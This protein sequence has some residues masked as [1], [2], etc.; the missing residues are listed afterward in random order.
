MNDITKILKT[1]IIDENTPI[2]L[3]SDPLIKTANV[4][5][6]VK[7]ED[8]NNK[9]FSGNKWHKLKYN[10][11]K[12]KE[13]GY[14]KL[15]TFGGAF[16]NHIYAVAAAGRIFG[17]ETIGIIRGEEYKQ[18]NPTLSFAR[19]QGMKFHYI[20][21]KTYRD[22]YNKDLLN[23]FRQKFGNFYLIPE[24]GTNELAVNGVSEFVSKINVDYDYICCSCG[25]GGTLA[26]IIEGVD[27]K[28]QILG[29][30]VL[31]GGEFLIKNVESL[32]N[33]N[34]T[35]N[36][37]NW[38]INLD[39]HFGG[40][41]K[42]NSR[43]TDFI[44]RFEKENNIPLEPIYTGKMVYGIYDLIF[45]GYFDKGKTILAIHTGGLQGLEGMKGK[46]NKIKALK[47][48]NNKDFDFI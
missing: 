27:H 33:K 26:G 20:D 21:R 6:L 1:R 23:D 11:I 44:E 3:I 38:K 4:N 25:T 8:L 31:K 9:Y 36:F 15:L 41:A 40:Y 30:S 22:K 2:Q 17:F 47:L 32:I 13:K 12:A 16:S 37:M 46:I 18:L 19:L 45:K 48:S 10:L 39:Y 34:V 7:R 14:D 28:R 5:L 24:G 43:L 29:F 35:E 42:I